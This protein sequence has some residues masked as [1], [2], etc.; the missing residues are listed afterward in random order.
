MEPDFQG[1][2]TKNGLKCADGRVIMPNAFEHQDTMRV[3]LVWQHDHRDPENVLGHVILKNRED[4]VWVDAYFNAT[5]KGKHAKH[6]VSHE[7]ITQMSIWANQLI[8]RAKR[9]TH[10]V[11]KEVSLVLSGAN[12]GAL[13]DPITIR[14]GDD[15]LEELVDEA[16]IYTGTQL[17]H[18]EAEEPA[19]SGAEEPE[20]M[21]ENEEPE[22]DDGATVADVLE[23]MSDEQQTVVNFLVGEALEAG[24]SEASKA[25]DES[26]STEDVVEQGNMSSKELHMGGHNVFEGNDSEGDQGY[27]LSHDDMKG[28]LE[29]AKDRGSVGKAVKDFALEHGI[30][31]IDILFPDAQSVQNQPDMLRRRTEWV[32]KFLGGSRKSPFSRIKTQAFDLTEDEARAKGYITGNVKTEEFVNATKRTTE[33]TTIYKKQKLDRDD[34]VDITD[35]DVVAFLKGEMRLMLDE[36]IARAGLLSDG[37]AAMHDDKVNETHI[38]PVVSDDDLFAVKVDV[39]IS[40]A[41]SSVQEIIDALVMNR[42][43]YKGTG[44]PTMFTTETLIS[45][46]LLLKD[47][48]GRRIYSSLADLAGEL[49]VSEIVAVEPMEDISG[50]L[51]IVVNPTDYTYGATAGGEVTM[52]DDFDIDYNQQKYLIE[53]R[54]CGALT[55]LKSALVVRSVAGTDTMASPAVPAF[56]GEDIVI[57]DTTGVT[58][59][60]QDDNTLTNGGGPYTLA[61][62]EEMIITATADSTYYFANSEGTEW[63]FVNRATA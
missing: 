53:T 9:V 20:P 27:E 4:G 34:M 48:L 26:E 22:G 45:Q 19:E 51:A 2:A 24:A 57:T 12:P 50:L 39:N 44:M 31:N 40:D 42:R 49:R 59:K 38:R 63:R 8:E 55:T 28:I 61:A 6:L 60:D 32:Q 43:Y 25:S 30:D 62:Q 5:A 47:T 56:D 7:D 36:E 23:D 13:I 18:N 29:D 54:A 17:I 58:Y 37:R 1:Y 52:F 21:A 10:G 3:P 41:D 16:I 11:I 33:P 14:H 46:F 15:D 35:F